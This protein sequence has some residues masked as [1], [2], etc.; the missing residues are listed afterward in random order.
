ME[1]APPFGQDRFMTFPEED[2]P[3]PAKKLFSPPVLDALGV[4]ELT[5]Y[6][7]AL[8]EEITRVRQAIAAKQAHAAAAASFFKPKD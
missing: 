1:P 6:I 3:R 4:E 5:A 8:E 2:S 7:T